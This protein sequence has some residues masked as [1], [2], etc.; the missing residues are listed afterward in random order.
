MNDSGLSI[1]MFCKPYQYGSAIQAYQSAQ[2]VSSNANISFP[3]LMM[4]RKL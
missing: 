2:N 4:L 3:R 1:A